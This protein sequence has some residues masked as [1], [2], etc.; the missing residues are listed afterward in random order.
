MWGA[1]PIDASTYVEDYRPP[2]D[3]QP[4]VLRLLGEGQ[5][6]RTNTGVRIIVDSVLQVPPT[7]IPCHCKRGS[8]LPR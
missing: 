8:R 6:A 2:V 7:P 3:M 1:E 4:P 5:R